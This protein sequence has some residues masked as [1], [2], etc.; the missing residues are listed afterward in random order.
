MDPTL[1]TVHVNS[2]MKLYSTSGLLFG[3]ILFLKKDE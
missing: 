1:D 3:F 2:C